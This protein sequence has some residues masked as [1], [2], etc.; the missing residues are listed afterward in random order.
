MKYHSKSSLNSEADLQKILTT[1]QH[2]REELDTWRAQQFLVFP[3]LCDEYHSKVLSSCYQ[4][5]PEEEPLLLPSDFSEPHRVY[6]DLSLGERAEKELRQGRAHDQLEDVRKAVQ[7]YN[8]HVAMK[9]KEVRSQRHITR[10]QRIINDLRDNI[11]RPAHLYN[12]TRQ[13]LI[14]LG[15]PEDDS[16]LRE[17]KDNELW[18]KN[19]ALPARLGDSR[20]S[21]PWYWHVGCPASS[22]A[23]QSVDFRCESKPFTQAYI[24]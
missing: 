18:A 5:N 10:A 2:L 7:T 1:R 9:A 19:S 12:K 8:H 6:L 13:G 3:K 22:S 11:R 21:D 23:E 20:T 17:L 16:I 15:L 4:I 14:S 24:V